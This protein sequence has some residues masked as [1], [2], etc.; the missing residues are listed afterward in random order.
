MKKDFNPYE[1]LGVKSDATLETIK[2]KYR[3]LAFRHHPDVGGDPEEFKKISQ[4]YAILSDPSNRKQYDQTGEWK[5][6]EEETTESKAIKRMVKTFETV[7]IA[8]FKDSNLI[9]DM[10]KI[11]EGSIGV[12]K[13][14][15]E[16]M[17]KKRKGFEIIRAR[18]KQR[19]E[20]KYDPVL[21]I[22]LERTK[23]LALEQ[24]QQA[25]EEIEVLKMAKAFTEEYEYT[26]ME[27]EDSFGS[28]AF[29]FLS[30][31]GAR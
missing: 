19:K 27:R 15:I 16:E 12:Q 9:Y 4:A 8:S 5:K 17:E 18:M 26:P 2:K 11:L 28:H 21:L 10:C 31:Y 24:I 25:K 14:M 23:T 6:Q 1:V 20:A 22:I 13:N 29:R 3:A 7:L 30:D